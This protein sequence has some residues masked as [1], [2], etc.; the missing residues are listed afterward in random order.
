MKTE[1][2]TIKDRKE[3]ESVKNWNN[4]MKK[5]GMYPQAKMIILVTCGLCG[6]EINEKAFVR[7]IKNKHFDEYYKIVMKLYP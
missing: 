7:H 5:I 2:Q 1:L 3:K 4:H 6:E